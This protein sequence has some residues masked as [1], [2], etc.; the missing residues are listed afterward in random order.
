[1][2]GDQGIQNGMEIKQP[3][4][5]HEWVPVLGP[6]AADVTNAV[7]KDHDDGTLDIV[8]AE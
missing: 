3:G 7:L 4:S 8:Y 5:G 2:F 6:Q 1:M